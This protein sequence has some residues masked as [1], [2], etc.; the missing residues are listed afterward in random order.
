MSISKELA[1]LVRIVDC[2]KKQLECPIT[3]EVPENPV[4]AQDGR[5]YEE[6]AF[7]RLQIVNGKKISPMTREEINSVGIT[8][9]PLKNMSDILKKLEDQ[10]RKLFETHALEIKKTVEETRQQMQEQMQ[11]EFDRRCRNNAQLS[12]Q[13]CNKYS[14]EAALAEQVCN[15]YSKEA[16]LAEDRAK[17]AE[18]MNATLEQEIEQLRA[19]A[20]AA[21]DLQTKMRTEITELKKMFTSEQRSKWVQMLVDKCNK[22]PGPE[23][24]GNA[25][26]EIVAFNALSGTQQFQDQL[27]NMEKKSIEYT[28][29]DAWNGCLGTDFLIGLEEVIVAKSKSEDDVTAKLKLLFQALLIRKVRFAKLGA[30]T[31]STQEP[32]FEDITN[33]IESCKAVLSAQN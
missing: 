30:L 2:A 17:K 27:E 4:V 22:N 8:V 31:D 21:Q 25:C 11:K 7:A 1:E 33:F 19:A 29:Q 24:F 20:G 9:H 14:T 28:L 10:V 6:H 26:V 18:E 16:A 5:V 12:F 32:D 15:K 13:I 3:L 23:D